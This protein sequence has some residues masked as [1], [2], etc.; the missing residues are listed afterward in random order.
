MVVRQG[1]K[2][3]AL[4]DANTK[5]SIALPAHQLTQASSVKHPRLNAPLLGAHWLFSAS[6]YT[7]KNTRS[8]NISEH[9]IFFLQ[10][11]YSPLAGVCRLHTRSR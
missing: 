6:S 8:G 1:M 11:F 5:S 10:G 2:V 9:A 4:G 3:R 7:R